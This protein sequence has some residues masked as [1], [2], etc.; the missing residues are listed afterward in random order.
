MENDCRNIYRAARRAAGLTQERWA[1]VLGISPDAVRKYEAGTIL[2]SDE[3]VLRMAEAAGQWIL[4]YWHLIRK[5]R[6][7][8]RILPEV[9]KR[10][11]PEA[12][13]GVMCRIEDFT[14]GGLQDLKQLAADGKI[15]AEEICAYGDAIAQLRD[16]IRAAYELEFA[17]EAEP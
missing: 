10:T 15:S 4:A 17:E 16:V 14:K 3:V 2:P 13:L 11:L 12:V 9:R 7:A 6:A 1:E 5:S 8:G